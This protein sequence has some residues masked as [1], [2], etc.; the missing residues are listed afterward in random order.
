MV[1][2]VKGVKYRCE[3]FV[4][5]VFCLFFAFCSVFLS[6]ISLLLLRDIPSTVFP[7]TS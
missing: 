6:Q 3:A 7:D 5:A 4:R 2:K 1:G